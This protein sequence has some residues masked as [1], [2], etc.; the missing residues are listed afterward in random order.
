MINGIANSVNF[1]VINHGIEVGNRIY[2]RNLF[3]TLVLVATKV[4]LDFVSLYLLCSLFHLLL[5]LFNHFLPKYTSALSLILFCHFFELEDSVKSFNLFFGFGK[6]LTIR[7]AVFKDSRFHGRH[8]IL[9]V[10]LLV[11]YLVCKHLAEVLE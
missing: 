1:T 2:T 6:H 7:S 9:F 3:N 4:H 5:L 10:S 8:F 11:G